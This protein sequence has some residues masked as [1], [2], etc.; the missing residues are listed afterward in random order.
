MPNQ[1]DQTNWNHLKKI[2]YKS[3]VIISKFYFNL[4]ITF[5]FCDATILVSYLKYF[6]DT[7]IIVF[8]FGDFGCK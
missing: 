7:K 4:K 5:N 1:F 6:W 2:V 3:K 8:D